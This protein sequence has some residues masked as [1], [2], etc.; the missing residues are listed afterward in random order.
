M[1]QLPRGVKAHH[2]QLGGVECVPAPRAGIHV[3]GLGFL[4][5]LLFPLPSL[6]LIWLS[7]QTGHVRLEKES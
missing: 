2:H 6:F 3:V 7:R 4:S 1:A 5:L